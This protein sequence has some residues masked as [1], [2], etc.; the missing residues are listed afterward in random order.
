M[1]SEPLP[2]SVLN[3]AAEVT[4]RHEIDGHSIYVVSVLS[5]DN[6][7]TSYAGWWALY[8]RLIKASRLKPD[9]AVYVHFVEDM[10]KQRVVTLSISLG[11][12]L[13]DVL[14][15]IP[16]TEQEM[17]DALTGK[18][19]FVPWYAWLM[20][21][22]MSQETVAWNCEPDNSDCAMKFSYVTAGMLDH[23]W[24]DVFRIEQNDD[25]N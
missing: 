6:A 8:A 10:D 13:V 20:D 19:G 5:S 11:Y 23:A 4:E 25:S 3:G 21:G 24:K 1:I 14:G 2:W 17:F 9:H 16:E 18:F 15:D 12:E 7:D 22:S